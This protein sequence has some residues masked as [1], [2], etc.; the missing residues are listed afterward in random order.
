[1]AIVVNLAPDQEAR[2]RE[3][4]AH[5][6]LSAEELAS[7]TVPAAEGLGSIEPMHSPQVSKSWHSRRACGPAMRKPSASRRS[8]T[9]ASLPFWTDGGG[10]R[11]SR[12]RW[13]AT[14]R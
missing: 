1:M 8:E 13:K 7:R 11:L 6:G 10:S 2:F 12:T 4:A 3:R 9:C 5:L 14:R